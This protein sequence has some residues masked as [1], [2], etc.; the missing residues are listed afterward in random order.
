LQYNVGSGIVL[1]S[2]GPDEYR[3]CLL[4]AAVLGER[5]AEI[6]E[7][8]RWT[9]G[10]GYKRFSLH[11]D[12][13]QKSALQLA[14]PLDL[15]RLISKLEEAVKGKTVTQR[16]RVALDHSGSIRVTN[17]PYIHRD[18]MSIALSKYPLS[19][20]VQETAHKISR[21]QF[22]D[23]ER[24]RLKAIWTERG[25]RLDEVI[26]FGDDGLLREGSFTSIFVKIDGQLYTPP[27]G[28]ILPGV[29][30]REWVDEGKAIERDLTLADLQNADEIFIGNSLRGVM[31]AHLLSYNCL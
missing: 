16:V 9:P 14:Y 19:T 1:D 30:R 7:T 26:F 11:K 5:R 15:N 6:I 25:E 8:M 29:L 24:E 3:E 17:T 21:R 22:Y 13:L 23:G 2:D 28:H 12:R 27:L 10:Y 18:K 4:K 31:K 20:R